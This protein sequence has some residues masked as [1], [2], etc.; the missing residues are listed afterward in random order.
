MAASPEIRTSTY[1]LGCLGG[2][3][4]TH[5]ACIWQLNSSWKC[6]PG[7]G[8]GSN[9]DLLHTNRYLTSCSFIW[10]MDPIPVLTLKAGGGITSPGS[11]LPLPL[12]QLLIAAQ[13][14][15]ALGVPAS[16]A[17]PLRHPPPN[18]GPP[19]LKQTKKQAQLITRDAQCAGSNFLYF[20]HEKPLKLGPVHSQPFLSKA[21]AMLGVSSGCQG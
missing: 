8:L 1:P 12:Q 9:L 3:N 19:W 6:R 18:L 7:S 14:C 10:K 16:P 15:L 17:T 21:S 4:L 5:D 11:T 13:Q 20:L 2:H